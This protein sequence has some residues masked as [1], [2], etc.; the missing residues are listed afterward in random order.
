MSNSTLPRAAAKARL[1]V[2][3]RA[4]TCAEAVKHHGDQGQG[5]VEYVGVIV[6]VALIIVAL[7]GSGVAGDIAQALTDKVTAILGS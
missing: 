5:A 7:V 6:L 3:T 4:R 2:V 1:A